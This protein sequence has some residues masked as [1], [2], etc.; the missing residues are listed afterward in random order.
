MDLT[1]GHIH[2]A[3]RYWFVK[4]GQ[5]CS[6]AFPDESI[7]RALHQGFYLSVSIWLGCRH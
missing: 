4:R 7:H 2:E 6:I 3:I 5:L 1:R